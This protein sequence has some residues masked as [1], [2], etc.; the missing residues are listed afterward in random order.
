MKN[1]KLNKIVIVLLLL[2]PIIDAITGIQTRYNFGFITIGKV[3]RGLAF[4][5]MLY[6]LFRKN[7]NKKYLLL[8][9]AYVFLAISN[10]EINTYNNIYTEVN[11]MFLIFYLPFAIMFFRN[12][13][14]DKVTDKLVVIIYTFYFL[15]LTIPTIFNIGF[16]A[17][18]GLDTKQSYLGFF[19]S[20]NELSAILIGLLPIVVVYL[21]KSKNYILKVLLTLEII[22]SA[23]LI[24]TKTMFL[25]VIIVFGYYL[26]IYTKYYAKEISKKAK[27]ILVS[28]IIILIPLIMFIVP[29][30]P[31]YNNMKITLEHYNIKEVKDIFKIDNIDNLVFSKRLSYLKNINNE[32]TKGNKYTLMYGI[33]RYRLLGIRDIEIDIFD[34]FYSIG[35]F[36]LFVYLFL[37]LSAKNGAELKG[38]YK[39]SFYLFIIISLF[40]GHVLNRPMVATYIALLFLLNSNSIDIEKK[41]ILLV[42]NMYPSKKYKHYGSFVKNTRDILIQ[43]G[44][45][46]DKVVMTKHDSKIVK[47]FAYFNFYFIT[48]IKGIFNNYDYIYVHFISHSSLGAVIL[49]KISK[50]TKLVF[51]AH[52]NDVVIDYDRDNKNIIRSKKYLKYLDKV[53]VPSNYFKDVMIKEYN[54]EKDKIYIYPSGGVNTEKFTNIDKETAKKN[55]GLS[56]NSNYIGYVSRLEKNKGYDVFLKSIPILL[57]DKKF[58]NYKFLV[59][60]SGNEENEFNK[61]VDELGIREYI[62]VKSFVS[63]DELVNI[64]NSLDIFVFPTY[65]K[66]ESLGLVGLEAMSCK[67]IVIAS[68]NY[69][70]SDYIVDNENGLFFNPKDHVDLSN[71][72][73]KVLKMSEKGKNEIR[74]K[75]RETA[76]K[77]D[78][79]NTKKKILEVFK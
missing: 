68:N 33:G 40:S 37:F 52:G 78:N 14:N 66:S 53:V 61:L 17:Y 48:I 34:I 25:G 19:H 12:I 6:Y 43:N 23:I 64:Y 9:L 47:L 44:Y 26:F 56:T 79:N 51:N 57:K 72:I 55:A 5:F 41:S 58:K 38:Q 76:L 22:I 7:I 59:V 10:Y 36:G 45:N 32:Y 63:Q 24:G 21:F 42:S 71:K 15:L 62:E 20:G 8:F 3:I 54:I 65:R 30:T 74:E 39:F 49:K 11:N 16:S 50:N 2:S 13:K 4:I 29:K 69:G 77:Y 18:Y 60:G 31:L 27:I 28:M 35:I 1:D 73:M 46:V 67:T 70:P 75:A